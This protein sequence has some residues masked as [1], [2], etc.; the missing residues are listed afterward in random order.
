MDVFGA[1]SW[2]WM[3]ATVL[4]RTCAYLSL[5][6]KSVRALAGG[7]AEGAASS[8]GRSVEPSDEATRAGNDAASMATQRSP[9]TRLA[10]KTATPQFAFLKREDCKF[11]FLEGARTSCLFGKKKL[12]P[13]A[14]S[15]M[16]AKRAKNASISPCLPLAVVTAVTTAGRTSPAWWAYSS[17]PATPCGRSAR[18]YSRPR[19]THGLC[20]HVSAGAG[21]G[22]GFCVWVLCKVA[23]GPFRT[24]AT[25]SG[26]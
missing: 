2:W 24:P 21:A 16:W 11:A 3:C 10:H 20:W 17:S 1:Q 4:A 15:H 13:E 23:G 7:Q 25:L 12:L 18:R 22:G 8:C 5:K 19:T 9:R 14:A 6:L 26:E